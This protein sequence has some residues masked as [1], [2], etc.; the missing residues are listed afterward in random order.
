[1][2]T[3]QLFKSPMEKIAFI[4][5]YLPRKCGIATFTSDLA[6]SISSIAPEVSC[7]VV[8]MNDTPEGY[9]YPPRVKYVINRYNLSEYIHAA[10]F[11]NINQ[12]DVVCLQHEYGIFGG[13]DGSNIIC[14]L[15]KL[16]MPV[17]VTLH[18]VLSQPSLSEKN[19]IIEL[20]HL[21]D[22]LVVLCPEA[23]KILLE[24]YGIPEESVL[25]IPHGIPDH[26]FVDSDSCKSRLGLEGMKIIMTFGLI[27]PQKGIEYVIK[28]LPE[29]VNRYPNV[30]YIIQGTTHPQVKQEDGEDYRIGLQ[31]L[32][33]NIGVDKHV[34]FY[35]RFLETNDLYN[36]IIA[37]DIYI[38]PYLDE[39]QISSGT[40]SYAM[41][42]GKAIIST[43]YKYALEMLGETRGRIV[44]FRNH[45]AISDQIIDLLDNTVERYEMCRRA[46]MFCRNAIWPRVAQQYLMLFSTVHSKRTP[47]LSKIPLTKGVPVASNER[48]T[49]VLPP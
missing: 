1:M 13:E 27:A 8:A 19:I 11:L 44:P 2:N 21:S 32:A 47:L 31:K 12:A 36:F 35:D 38:T 6:E 9:P 25:F 41:G 16:N 10:D 3:I 18:T 20:A 49:R 4:G 45:Q 23:K 48:Y 39:D 24:V 40:L 7:I 43:P 29:V 46:Y 42:C 15:N 26:S 37:A 22:K 28:A 33:Q 5:N 14:L 17:V 34:I 30:V